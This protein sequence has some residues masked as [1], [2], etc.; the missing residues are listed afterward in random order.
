M[1]VRRVTK[2]VSGRYQT[3]ESWSEELHRA[4]G[5]PFPGVYAS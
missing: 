3:I 1:D 2:K 5:V 4:P